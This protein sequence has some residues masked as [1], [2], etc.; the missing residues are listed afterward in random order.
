M[1]VLA[2][3]FN[4]AAREAGSQPLT[5]VQFDLSE[6]FHNESYNNGEEVMGNLNRK[7]AYRVLVALAKAEA[8][9]EE[10]KKEELAF[11]ADAVSDEE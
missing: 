9:K 7:E 2:G 11:F 3:Y 8:A 5:S 1:V 4:Q 6:A 10:D